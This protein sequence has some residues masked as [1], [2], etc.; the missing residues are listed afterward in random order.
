MTKLISQT[1][2]PAQPGYFKLWAW[3]GNNGEVLFQK[4]TIIAWVVSIYS[5]F[6]N[7]DPHS[8]CADPV[9]ADGN[10][11]DLGKWVAVLNPEGFVEEADYP[12]VPLQQWLEDPDLF[13]R[14]REA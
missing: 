12:V 1:V 3:R 13:K 9:G 6:R 4:E 5:G 14:S 11:S 10:G 2:V 7:D 8:V